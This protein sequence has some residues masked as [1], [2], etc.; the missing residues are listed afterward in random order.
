MPHGEQVVSDVHAVV[1]VN[2]CELGQF[3]EVLSVSG[4]RGEEEMYVF[5]PGS[6][7]L[8]YGR[9]RNSLTES[10]VAK[11]ALQATLDKATS[12]KGSIQSSL[13]LFLTGKAT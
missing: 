8:T 13:L 6:V 10:D 5:R 2:S 9:C 7:K 11:E 1:V 3:L 4:R 12:W